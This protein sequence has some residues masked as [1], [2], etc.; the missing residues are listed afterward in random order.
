MG[1]YAGVSHM[2]MARYDADGALDTSFGS[3]AG[4]VTTDFGSWAICS[5]V[6]VDGSGKIV[7]GGYGEAS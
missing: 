7:A 2:A 3:G 1:A 4:Y 5:S 6:L